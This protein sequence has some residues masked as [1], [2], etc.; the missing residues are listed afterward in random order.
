MNKIFTVDELEDKIIPIA[1]TYGV[2]SVSLFG[3][4]ASGEA[5]VGSDVDILIDKGKIHGLIQY[6]SFIHDLEDTLGC[7]V[8]VITSGIQDKNFLNEIKQEEI[9]LYEN[10]FLKKFT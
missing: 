2:G 9:L 6:F 5:D 1:K 3:S 10:K 7:H 4:Y 8:D